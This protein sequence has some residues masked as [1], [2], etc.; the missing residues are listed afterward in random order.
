MINDNTAV[1]LGWG[2]WKNKKGQFNVEPKEGASPA[3]HVG[4]CTVMFIDLGACQMTASVVQFSQDKMTT[5]TTTHD[6]MLG[7]R[8]IDIEI[9]KFLADGFKGGDIFSTPKALIKLLAA[10]EKAKITLSGGIAKTRVYVEC[11]MNDQDLS[12]E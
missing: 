4:P 10:S 11:I 9:A 3:E 7:S 1:A 5:L 8:L 12:K 6:K 2:I